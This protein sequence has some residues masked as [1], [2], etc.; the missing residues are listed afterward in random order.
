MMIQFTS[1]YC[2]YEFPDY[3]IWVKN[4]DNQFVQSM[5]VSSFDSKNSFIYSF[6]RTSE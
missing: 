6:Y 3:L 2:V 4:R 5:Q 1:S